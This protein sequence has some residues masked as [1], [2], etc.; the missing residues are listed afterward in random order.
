YFEGPDAAIR[1][2]IVDL[3]CQQMAAI[4]ARR[5]AAL[6]NGIEPVGHVIPLR[7]SQ[8]GTV[9]Q[10]QVHKG[11]GSKTLI[12]HLLDSLIAVGNPCSCGRLLAARRD[13]LLSYENGS[14]APAGGAELSSLAQPGGMQMTGSNQVI[15]APDQVSVGLQPVHDCVS[16]IITCVETSKSR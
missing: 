9:F 10:V 11:I 3:L 5:K 6:L 13:D 4:H 12:R 2:K 14:K 1:T 8:W 16:G 15:S 7:C